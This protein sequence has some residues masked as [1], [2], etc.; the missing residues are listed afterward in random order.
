MLLKVSS[1]LFVRNARGI[2]RKYNAKGW[3]ELEDGIAFY[4][5]KWPA[6]APG[7]P[8]VSGSG[9]RHRFQEKKMLQKKISFEK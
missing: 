4:V 5:R 7:L 1:F 6:P 2:K 3:G 8:T 9:S